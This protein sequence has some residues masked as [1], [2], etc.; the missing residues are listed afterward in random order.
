MSFASR[1]TRHP[2]PFD[3]SLAADTL[4]GLG[5]VDG[6]VADLLSGSA[7]CS[8]YLAGLMTQHGAWLEQ[9]LENPEEA[10]RQEIEALVPGPQKDVGTAMRL[11]KQRVALL[12]A[13]ADL[14][15]VWPLDEVTGTLTRLADRA[16]DVA[17]KSALIAPLTRGKIPDHGPDD[18]D[19]AAGLTALAMGKMGAFELNYSSDIDLI[20]LFDD[21]RFSSDDL[22]EVRSVF[23]KAV[24]QAMLLLSDQKGDGYV[25]RT[26]LR[27]RP[28]PS[29]TPVAVPISAAERYYEALGRTWERTAYVKAR[30][31][32]GDLS[33]ARRF[34][35]DIRPFI[36][37]RHLDFT[38]VEDTHEM[39][40][41]IRAQKG[42]ASEALDGRNVKLSPG[43]IR[44][45]EFFAQTRQLIAGGRDPSLRVRGTREGL[46]ALA[47]TGWVS[48]D[49]TK[50][51]D[52]DYVALREMEH[53][54]Q[55]VQDA[56]THSLPTN[57]ENWQR[58][59][60][61]TGGGDVDR[62][63]EELR[64]RFERVYALTEEFFAPSRA[65]AAPRPEMEDGI[66]RLVE[67]WENYPALRSER[68]REILQRILPDLLAGFDRAA[69]P[70]EALIQFDGFLKGLPAGVQVLS[71]FEA[72]PQLIELMVDISSTAPALARY[73]SRN[74]GVLDAVIGGD[75]FET[76]PGEKALTAELAAQLENPD[77]DY[78]RQL[79][80]ARH[81]MKDWHF[82]IGVHHLR[83]LIGPGDAALEY[84][85]LA[86]ATV[87]G[88]W[89]ATLAEFARKHGVLPGRGAIVLGMG[90]L[91]A[92]RLSAGSDL[93]L[94]VIYDAP[95]D[96]QSDGK[97][98]LN[99]RTY[100]AR[101]T[102]ALV[103][104]L[105]AQTAAGGLY[106]VDMRLRP[107]GRQGPAA[108]SWTAYQVY[109]REEA[110]T[111]EHLA[112]TR[113]RVVAGNGSL[114]ADFENFR[115][116]LLAEPRDAGALCVDLSDMRQRLADAKPQSGPW[117]VSNGPGGLQDIELFAQAV[118]LLAGC[119]DAQV[120]V[121]LDQASDLSSAADRAQLRDAEAL[122]SAVKAVS[123]L[124]TDQ[125]LDPAQLGHGGREV[126]RRDSGHADL[127]ELQT[128]LD[129]HR[130]KAARII[131]VALGHKEAADGDGATARVD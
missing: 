105:S 89:Q 21:S 96:A 36:W 66:K 67:G 1:L 60:D 106:E 70:E 25:F 99:T 45:I 94:I 113:A 56:Q 13:L 64:E 129:T 49:V 46:A 59:A 5:W 30:P 41:K 12:T 4:S 57:R 68:A 54:L 87:S 119:S 127:G 29:A 43:G 63:Q 42:R 31:C 125:A 51:L 100:Y 19:T 110:W 131:D 18:L 120:S 91:G 102:K 77:L 10:A 126:L 121:Q 28:D 86:D 112:L 6:D 103:T 35:K 128:A 84:S 79:D 50:V 40:L 90:S 39:R 65:P 104:S 26:D 80:A 74:S 109:Q 78:E 8:P 111:W 71:L 58:L 117:D 44:E 75:F 62:L 114:A 9:A 85:D 61:F 123:R 34:L 124:L 53:R 116:A 92:R 15:G 73:L 118:A 20:C 48:G 27:L 93:D 52:A 76:W 14:G 2:I 17:L 23:V 55:M 115:Q 72:N 22:P 7:G 38:T 101:L 88:L 3:P 11:A 108:T 122:F 97:R 95:M 107:S 47:A 83:G 82:R 33:A 24:R 32:A 81:W 37:R 69:S 16:T 98:S 130:A